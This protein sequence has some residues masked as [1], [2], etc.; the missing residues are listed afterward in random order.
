MEEIKLIVPS[1]EY[2]EDIFGFKREMLEANDMD[3]FAGC[4]SLR[5]CNNIEEYLEVLSCYRNEDTCPK[6]S[7]PSDTYIAVRISDNKVVGIIDLRH[8]IN[9]PILSAWGGHL[10][11]SIRP[12]ERRK[13]YAKEMLR[14]NLLKC[15]ERNKIGIA[16]CRE[17]VLRLVYITVVSVS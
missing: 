13:G 3:S 7:V 5:D 16:S 14:L 10:G 4:G 12:S 15:K 8:H 6:G 9:H 17:R 1:I 11:Y 2:G